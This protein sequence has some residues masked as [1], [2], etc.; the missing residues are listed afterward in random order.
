MFVDSLSSLEK[1]LFRSLAQFLIGSFGFWLFFFM[2]SCMSCLY[3]WSLILCQLLHLQIFSPSL[4][5]A[6]SSYLW[7]DSLLITQ[8]L[9][10]Q[11]PACSLSVSLIPWRASGSGVGQESP[12][13]CLLLWKIPLLSCCCCLLFYCV[14]GHPALGGV[15][16]S[17]HQ[18]Q[19]LSFMDE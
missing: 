4:K 17:I 9:L 8:P 7:L 1:C 12:G 19:D 16:L 5:V 14:L 6:I 15:D 3:I 18:V 10:T 11:G 13:V 2:L